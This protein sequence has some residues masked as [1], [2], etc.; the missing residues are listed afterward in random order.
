MPRDADCGVSGRLQAAM[1]L[2]WAAFIGLPRELW[3]HLIGEER[4]AWALLREGRGMNRPGINGRCAVHCAAA[5]RD[6]TLLQKLLDAG[7]DP[8]PASIF[9]WTLP[10][11]HVA[12]ASA[13]S[14]PPLPRVVWLL[15][16]RGAAVGRCAGW[17]RETVLALAARR[18]SMVLPEDSEFQEWQEVLAELA[19]ASGAGGIDAADRRGRTPLYSAAHKWVIAELLSRG[20]AVHSQDLRGV[21]AAHLPR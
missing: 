14:V 2:D 7:A 19:L 18:A 17:R 16:A 9:P 1:R 4:R 21:R 13:V 12:V 3:L 8:D 15:L 20:A 6:A 10:P 11:L 5:L